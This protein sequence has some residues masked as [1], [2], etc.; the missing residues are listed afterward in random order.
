MKHTIFLLNRKQGHS[1]CFIAHRLTATGM[2]LALVPFY[3]APL[4]LNPITSR[5]YY[6]LDTVSA[7]AHPSLY[8]SQPSG[9]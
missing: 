2:R 3:I 4:T 6:I 9:L 8:Q 1:T 7:L 5:S